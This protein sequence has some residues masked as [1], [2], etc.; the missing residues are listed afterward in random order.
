MSREQAIAAIT[1]HYDSGDFLGDLARRVA[2]KTESQKLDERAEDMAAYMQEMT[3]T[4]TP[5][6]YECQTMANPHP[7]GGPFMIAKRVEDPDLPTVFT[8]GHGDVVRGLAEQWKDGLDPWKIKVDGDKVYGRGTADNKG[9]HS[10]NIAAIRTV[11]ETRGKLGFNST[12]MIESSEEVGSK[13]LGEFAEANKDLLKAD[14]LIGSDGPRLQPGMPTLFMGTRGAM[15][16]TLTCDL[17]E[18]GHHS[19]NW[20]GLISNPGT[21]LANAISSLVDKRGQILVESLRPKNLTNSIRMAL[22]GLEVDGGEEGPQ[23]EP[24]WGEESLIPAERVFAWNALEVLT[25]VTGNP[26]KPVNA[27]PPRAIANCQLRFIVDTD[28]DAIIPA[29]QAHLDEHGFENV[30]AAPA[31]DVAM[32]ATRL[33]PDHPWV[34]WAAKSI[35]K[36]TDKKPAIIPNLGGSLPNDVFADTLGLP[37][38]WVPH[39][40]ASCSQHAPNEHALQSIMREGLQIM[41]GIFWD[42]GEDGTPP[43]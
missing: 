12:I 4:L 5:L 6:G 16:F 31:R 38:I 32:K 10:I 2:I 24:D 30:I 21:I 40:Y 17:R 26:N 7:V 41:T 29:I 1:E 42:L 11:L 20:G 13:G 14:L 23:V 37:T 34:Q 43:V 8:Y 15:N 35:T 9:Q 18:G 22:A 28:P 39:S 25:F 3:D 27:I 19:G 36:T 33:L